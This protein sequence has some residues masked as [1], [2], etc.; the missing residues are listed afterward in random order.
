MI[1]MMICGR[2]ISIIGKID[3]KRSYGVLHVAIIDAGNDCVS[4]YRL[5]RVSV[6]TLDRVLSCIVRFSTI[7][8]EIV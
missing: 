6:D 1:M 4:T 3:V 7:D 8:A 5:H 2:Q